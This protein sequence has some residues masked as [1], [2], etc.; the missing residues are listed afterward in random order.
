M[1]AFFYTLPGWFNIDIN[2]NPNYN[3]ICSF[4]F[5][6]CWHKNLGH[7]CVCLFVTA[8]RRQRFSLRAPRNPRKD[9][10]VMT[11]PVI[12]RMLAMLK[13]ARFGVRAVILKLIIMNTPKTSSATPHIWTGRE[14]THWW[15]KR[16][17][18]NEKRPQS[19]PKPTCQALKSTP[20]RGE[21]CFSVRYSS[22]FHSL[23]LIYLIL[24]IG[25]CLSLIYLKTQVCILGT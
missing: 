24:F 3:V 7:L 19:P 4:F 16:C 11:I 21:M 15:I 14:D 13:W 18:T 8:M 20:T 12:S 17:V 1:G 6:L 2:I 25:C 22:T 5:F 23:L 10:Q 9:T